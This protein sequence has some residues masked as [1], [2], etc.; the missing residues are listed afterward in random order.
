MVLML[1]LIM[2]QNQEYYLLLNTIKLQTTIQISIFQSNT[3]VSLLQ[4]QRPRCLTKMRFCY[5]T[6]CSRNLLIL[7]L[8]S[9]GLVAR[10][11]YIL[12]S[13][14]QELHFTKTPQILYEES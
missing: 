2:K 6:F 12:V 1:A 8:S 9:V 3:S 14:N 13:L 11:D 10:K 4:P 7:H 5:Y